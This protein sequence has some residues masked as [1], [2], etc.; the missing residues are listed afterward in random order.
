MMLRLFLFCSGFL[1]YNFIFSQ[2]SVSR[3][4]K[5]LKD[6]VFVSGDL[7]LA[8][9]IEFD[10]DKASVRPNSKD[11]VKLI[12]DFLIRNPFLIVEIS[13]HTDSHGNNNYNQILSLRRATAIVD[14]MLDSKSDSIFAER[15]IALGKG[16]SDPIYRDEFINQHIDNP[17][18]VEQYH[19]A[20]RRTEI[21]I[22]GFI[23][24]DFYD[25]QRAAT[26]VA[27]VVYVGSN[28]DSLLFVA[29][30]ALLDGD[31]QKAMEYYLRASAVAP[32]S[33]NYAMQQYKKLVLINE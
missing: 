2:S 26:N 12:V 30:K 21:K 3:Y 5:T 29:D 6:S 16:E 28:Y 23:H 31:H 9:R 17:N 13:T 20:N 8:P 19:Q 15:I 18:L 25:N 14:L 4:T 22:I 1:F 11:S 10:F 24:K 32:V 27:D 7:I 33:D